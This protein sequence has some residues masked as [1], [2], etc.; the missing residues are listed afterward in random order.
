[1]L[2]SAIEQARRFIVDEELDCWVADQ[3]VS[4]GINPVPGITLREASMVKRRIGVDDPKTHRG[5]RQWMQRWRRRRG[6]R[7]R[8]FAPSEPME[9]KDMHGKASAQ[10]D[11]TNVPAAFIFL[12]QCHHGATKTRPFSASVL[13][14]RIQRQDKKVSDNDRF[15]SQ[16]FWYCC[17]SSAAWRGEGT[18]VLE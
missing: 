7:L 3:N 6:L 9:K 18:V 1:M 13:R 5:A 12:P 11:A 8:K 17:A 16:K 10:M 15:F 4:K 14:P 2:H